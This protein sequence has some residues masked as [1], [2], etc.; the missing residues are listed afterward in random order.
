M[1]ARFARLAACAALVA[2]GARDTLDTLGETGGGGTGLGGSDEGAG[3][4]GA[5]VEV[6]GGPV[7]GAP[8]TQLCESPTLTP[9]ALLRVA[10]GDLDTVDLVPP[11]NNPNALCI[12]AH[13]ASTAD[14]L[15]AASCFEPYATWP[16]ELG[17][18]NMLPGSTGGAAFT[19]GRQDGIAML[20]GDLQDPSLD[21]ARLFPDFVPGSTELSAY[22][23]GGYGMHEAA[24]AT[25]TGTGHVAGLTF[26]AEAYY[27]LSVLRVSGDTLEVAVEVACGIGGVAAD[28]ATIGE[29]ALVLASTSRPFMNCGL[30]DGVPGPATR[31]QLMAFDGMD[32]RLLFDSV[33]DAVIDDVEVVPF[34]ATS[35]FAGWVTAGEVFVARVNLNGSIL[36][37]P[38][39]IANGAVGPIALAVR[40]EELL[41]A[42]IDATDPDAASD[43]VVTA[44]KATGELRP[45]GGFDTFEAPWR[46]G[47][48]LA[49]STDGDHVVVAYA[50]PSS[51]AA[52]RF[53]CEP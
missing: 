20:L 2:C 49:A 41:V 7:G 36:Y 52:R 34:D 14:A 4:S 11:T 1:S 46:G 8:P 18:A 3:A 9:P 33:H 25:R 31:I 12:G 16:D 27:D 42:H 51:V 32:A 13:S 44:M 53:D 6:G 30:D 29:T 38:V 15:V 35:M 19:Q 21:D 24:F 37:G 22:V 40:G 17:E 26:V 10:G 23:L 47:L 50:A 28:G 39:S 45:F 48:T 43:V 5:G